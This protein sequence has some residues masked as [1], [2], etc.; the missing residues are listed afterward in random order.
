MHQNRIVQLR[1]EISKKNLDAIFISNQY[2]VTFLSGFTGLSPNEREAFFLITDKK[3]HFIT[4]STYFG[5]F[6]T[7]KTYWQIHY[8][9]PFRNLTDILS[10][11]I[12][13]EKIK[14]MAVE[15]NGLNLSEY[16]SLKKK[17]G[18]KIIM[19]N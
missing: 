16:L 12:K 1:K 7:N 18:V 15:K 5:L 14:K 9:T 10:E 17:L 4:Y 13:K 19:D 2:N 8:A 11:I 6:D 3:V